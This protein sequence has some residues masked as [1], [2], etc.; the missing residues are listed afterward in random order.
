MGLDTDYGRLVVQSL[1]AGRP[2][3]DR[4][5][6]G[7]LSADARRVASRHWTPVR[8]AVRAAMMLTCG[9]ECQILDV[10]SGVGKF[11]M[12]GALTTPAQ[13][14]G[15]ERRKWLVTESREIALK[16]EIDRTRF[17][18]GNFTEVDWSEFDGIYLYNPFQENIDEGCRIDATVLMNETRFSEFT[19]AVQSKLAALKKKTRVV[20]FHGFGAPMPAGFVCA[21]KEPWGDSFLELWIKQS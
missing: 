15:V 20:T 6:N 8:F 2:V 4:F 16:L 14:V 11:C 17:I 12:V 5:F 21:A 10:G 1:R 18:C 13:F 3:S 7:L 19:E 9:K